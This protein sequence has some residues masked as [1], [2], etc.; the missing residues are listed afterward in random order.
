MMLRGVALTGLVIP[1]AV[2]RLDGSA[3]TSGTWTVYITKDGGTQGTIAGSATHEG[4]G[5]WTFNLTATEMDAAVVVLTFTHTDASPFS[6]SL[7]PAPFVSGTAQAGAS[8]TITLASGA[9]ATDSLYV[10]QVVQLG[11]GQSRVITGYVGSTKV[12]T[13]D[14]AWTTNPSSA[15]TYVLLPAASD[16]RTISGAAVSTSTAQLGVNVVN[17]GGSAGTFASGRPEVNAS[18]WGGTAVGST[19][20]RA[21]L[22]NIAGAAVSTSTAQLGVNVVNFGGSAGTFAS[23]RPEVNTTHAAGTA[24]GSGAITAASIATDAITAAKIAADAI[25]SSELAAD[26]ASEIAAAVAVN[27]G[28]G[29]TL[30]A[31][32]SASNLAIVASY[33]D[34]EVA[35]IKAKTDNLPSDPA[36]ASDIAASF[37]TVNST[38]A[39]IAGYIDTEV[40]AIKAKTDN[41]PASPA[42]TGDIPSAATVASQVR[43]ELTTELGLIDAAISTR[44]TPAQVNAEVVDALATDTYAEPG[45]VP[46][47]TSS[48]KDKINWL[49]TLARNKRTQTSSTQTLRNDA[50]NASISTSTVSDDGTTA[51]RGEWS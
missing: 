16:L 12:A 26:A 30:T 40:A 35:A 34:T 21:D 15:S 33:I 49:F 48:L 11:D 13:V 46:A 41:L 17:F 6:I 20:V 9:S 23:G 10:G 45:S 3:I 29:S 18:H 19:T 36:D 25:G 1:N 43:T 38:L 4:N 47:A 37:S 31:L 28:T 44:A 39:T 32:A 5:Q 8:T 2:K 22:I 42:A 24:W 27:L 50:D 51:T 14:R 7:V